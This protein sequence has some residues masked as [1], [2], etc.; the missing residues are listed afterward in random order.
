MRYLKK[1]PNLKKVYNCESCSNVITQ[2]TA[3]HG[4]GLCGSCSGYKRFRDPEERK[5]LSIAHMGQVGY[6]RGKKRTEM[7]GKNNPLYG[8]GKFGEENIAKRLE[9]RKVLSEI[10]KRRW[11]SGDFDGENS[12]NWQGGRSFEPYPLGWTK[13]F[14]EQIR[15]RDGYRCQLCGIPEVECNQRLHIHH[16]DYNKENINDNNL[17]S[18]C[19][20]CH[21]KTQGNR[22]Y[23]FKLFKNRRIQCLRV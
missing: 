2:E 9:V 5:R 13:T 16:I 3:F 20:S 19:N 1:Y 17:V 12:P 23:W 15:Y 18:L 8:K 21:G 10:A 6:W 4:S 11:A 14:K 22:N 7:M